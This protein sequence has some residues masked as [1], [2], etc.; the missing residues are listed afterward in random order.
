MSDVF[1]TG[2]NLL[3]PIAKAHFSMLNSSLNLEEVTGG[4][5]FF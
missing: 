1:H 2:S 3:R 4:V 5:M